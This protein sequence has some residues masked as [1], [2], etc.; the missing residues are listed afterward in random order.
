MPS[1][2]N[3]YMQLCPQES[4]HEKKKKEKKKENNFKIQETNFRSDEVNGFGV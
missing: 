2:N 1:N 3:L 4:M